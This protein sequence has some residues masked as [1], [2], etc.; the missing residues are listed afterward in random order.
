[1]LLC[2]DDF[3]DILFEITIWNVAV[4]AKIAAGL[5]GDDLENQLGPV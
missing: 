1:M 2:G 4:S 3:V 5:D